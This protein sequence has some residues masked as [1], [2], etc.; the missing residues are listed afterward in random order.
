MEE[1]AVQSEFGLQGKVIPPFRLRIQH[2][3]LLGTVGAVILTIRINWVDWH[4][5]PNEAVWAFKLQ[6]GLASLLYATAF[7]ALLIVFGRRWRFGRS[8]VQTP[9][10]WLLVFLATAA[11]ID[12]V[13][14]LLLGCY[15]HFYESSNIGF[16][17]WNLE[18]LLLCSM[19]GI[20]CF[21][22]SWLISGSRWWKSILTIPGVVLIA[23]VPQHVL[24]LLG[25][26][27]PWFPLAH[28]YASLGVSAVTM[29]LV[30]LAC[31]SDFSHGYQG[32]WLHWTG[33]FLIAIAAVTEFSF[34]LYWLMNW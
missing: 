7:T 15:R 23:L 30:V 21:I 3:F 18:K 12:G 6:V 11:L 33:V 28:V 25:T 20:A 19:V 26:W 9:G 8:E 16:E 29:P 17:A 27:R 24:A 22:F 13:V 2:F 32:N 34:A 4:E 31:Y 1:K 10:H 5:I 14:A